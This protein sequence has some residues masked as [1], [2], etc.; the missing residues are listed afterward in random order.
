MCPNWCHNTLTVS[1]DPSGASELARFVEQAPPRE[2]D[3]EQGW[4]ALR[5]R[6]KP[7]LAQCIEQTR[8]DQPLSFASFVPEPPQ[9]VYDQMVEDSKT[10][11]P[12]SVRRPKGKRPNTTQQEAG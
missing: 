1:T 3:I 6:D 2:Q 5:G 9:R 8:A 11:V 7:T 10:T 12:S 4:R